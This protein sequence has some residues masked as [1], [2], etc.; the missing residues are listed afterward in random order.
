VQ[1]EDFGTGSHYHVRAVYVHHVRGYL[2]D[3]PGSEH[4]YKETGGILFNITRHGAN[5][6]KTRF[7]DVLVENSDFPC[8]RHRLVD[9]LG[10]DVPR[11]RRAL[12]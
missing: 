3:A 7:D 12:W 11:W 6:R 5:Q 8:R 2:K 9:A 1:L 4:V 10:V